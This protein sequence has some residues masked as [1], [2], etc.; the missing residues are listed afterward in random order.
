MSVTSPFQPT[1]PA[2]GATPSFR[3]GNRLDLI[4][5]HA[6]R[7][8]SDSRTTLDPRTGSNFNPRSPHGERPDGR[9]RTS[10]AAKDFNPRS[11]HGERHNTL[12]DT[13]GIWS[14][15][16]HAPRT[17]SDCCSAPSPNFPDISTHAPR[18]GSDSRGVPR[19]R[20]PAWNFNPR[21]PHGERQ[22][23]DPDGESYET[24]QPTLPARGATDEEAAEIQQ[25]TFQPTLPARGATAPFSVLDGRSG[26]STHAPRTGSDAG[27]RQQAASGVHISTHAPRTGSD[28][29]TPSTGSLSSVFQPTLPARGATSTSSA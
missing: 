13:I 4:S 16:T 1:L 5:T 12:W 28:T 11:P 25:G 22:M 21:S 19:M 3:R 2:R 10:A 8:G 24:F 15:S 7:T 18:T 23:T 20:R 26:I 29:Q 9:R 27:H 14:I 6:P 17:G